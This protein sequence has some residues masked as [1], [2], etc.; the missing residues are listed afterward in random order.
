[1]FFPNR[2][3][4][5]QMKTWWRGLKASLGMGVELVEF[6]ICSR[7]AGRWGDLTMLLSGEY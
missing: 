1:M 4:I 3:T 2:K 5:Q 6:L 7:P